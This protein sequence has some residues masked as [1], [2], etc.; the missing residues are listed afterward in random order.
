MG[1]NILSVLSFLVGLVI[2]CS[3]F[4][5]QGVARYVALVLVVV[6]LYGFVALGHLVA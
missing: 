6:C 2:L 4:R 5:M 3:L 1:S